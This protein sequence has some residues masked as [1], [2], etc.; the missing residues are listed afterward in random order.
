MWSHTVIEKGVDRSKKRM[1]KKIISY[2]I[3][4]AGLFPIT[5]YAEWEVK[6]VDVF[7]GDAPAQGS[8]RPSH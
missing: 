8:L 5:T 3:L 1:L 7:D 2:V 4:L 6:V